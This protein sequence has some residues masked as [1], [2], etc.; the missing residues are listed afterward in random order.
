MESR[1]GTATS[2]RQIPSARASQE[3]IGY[4]LRRLLQLQMIGAFAVMALLLAAIGI[5]SNA[6]VTY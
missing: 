4:C 3:R 1:W 6:P 2:I 5:C